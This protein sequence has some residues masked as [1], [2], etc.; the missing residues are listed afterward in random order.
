MRSLKST[1]F[2]AAIALFA[3]ATP[4]RDYPV[5]LIATVDDM[6]EL[7]DVQA[8]VSE[9]RFDLAESLAG[10]SELTEQDWAAF[11]DMGT[12]LVATSARAEHL[13]PGE[14]FSRWNGV[15]GAQAASLVEAATFRDIEQTL[16][17]VTEIDET[18]EAC[19]DV[20]R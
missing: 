17:L 3:C 9:P 15:L 8:T 2:L 12:R 11:H 20:T 14:I 19:H 4:H 6:A 16:L 7:M 1:F 13:S 18:C 5:S 10:A